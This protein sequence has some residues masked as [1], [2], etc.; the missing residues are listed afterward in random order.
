MLAPGERG[1]VL[2]VF[3]DKPKMFE[4]WDIDV[5]YQEKQRE[6][7]QLQDCKVVTGSLRA[8]VS[9]TW[10]YMN[11]TIRQE[12]IL[13]GNNRRIDFQTQ[14]DWQERQQLLKVAFPVDV[15]ATEA[16]YD[17]QFGN[18]KRPTHWNTSWD[19]ARFETVG[20]QWV[21]LSE[22]GYG[23]SLLNDCKYGHDIKDH[24]IRLSLLKSAT[25]PDPQA[26]RGEHEFTYA[27]YPHEGHWSD[28]GTEQ[29][30]TLLNQP[31]YATMGQARSSSFSL[32]QTS[33]SADVVIDAVKKAE[34]GDGLIV[35]LHEYKGGRGRVR[36]HFGMP[37]ISWQETDMMERSLGESSSAAELELSMSPYEIKTIRLQLK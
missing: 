15:R 12:M 1:N 30:A 13:Y 11:S 5:F 24:V 7:E 6:V 35:R 34:D 10:T 2:Q 33:G 29:A 3:E 26:D 23:V 36:F 8:V 31:V 37:V 28:G 27:L 19:L 32:L 22:H 21:D 9:F 14:V 17:I 18:V 20:H 25:Y 16:T 4:A